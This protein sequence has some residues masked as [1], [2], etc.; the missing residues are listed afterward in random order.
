MGLL[1]VWVNECWSEG[2]LSLASDDPS[3]DPAVDERMLD[4]ELDRI[5]M[6]DGIRRL[7]DLAASDPVAAI[8]AAPVVAAHPL[9][10]P[11]PGAP[12]SELDEWILKVATDAQHICG[13]ARMGT[14]D[15]S[16]VDTHCRVHGI[17]R[18]RVADASVFPRVPRA[19]THLAV[20]AVA[21]RAADLMPRPIA[22]PSG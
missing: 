5:R 7:L 11:A 20:L 2:S 9:P 17:S 6:R 3:V 13:T 15:D 14:G 21:E 22:R 10:V 1:G 4:H 18:L 8:T 16:V 12:D 19:N